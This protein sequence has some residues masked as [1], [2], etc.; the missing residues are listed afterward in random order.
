MEAHE[1]CE[2]A[3]ALR[4]R[5]EASSFSYAAVYFLRQRVCL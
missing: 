1:V 4:V 3:D 2:V 5:Q